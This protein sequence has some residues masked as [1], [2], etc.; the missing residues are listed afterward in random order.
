MTLGYI[1]SD[2]TRTQENLG[3]RPRA[4]FHFADS[5]EVR[6]AVM[7][8]TNDELEANPRALFG[9]LRELKSLVHNLIGG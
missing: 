4:V 3:R 6:R 5:E 8:Y 2:T 1:L 7:D 9:R